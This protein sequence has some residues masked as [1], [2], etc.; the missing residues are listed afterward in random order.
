MPQVAGESGAVSASE[1]TFGRT[2]VG[3]VALVTGSGRG[4]GRAIAEQL[5]RLGADLALHDISDTAPAQYGE[6]ATI[7]ETAHQ[8]LG[9]DRRGL[10]VTGDVTVELAVKR[11]VETVEFLVGC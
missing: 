11:M 4:L 7:S 9:A 3:R 5:V 8:L 1:P 10:T 2:L 6:A